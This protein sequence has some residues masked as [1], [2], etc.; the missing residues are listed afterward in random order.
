MTSSSFSLGP[1]SDPRAIYDALMLI[2][3]PELVS[4]NLEALKEKYADESEEDRAA[5]REEYEKSYADFD[6]LVGSLFGA[7]TDIGKTF[8]KTA[9]SSAEAKSIAEDKKVLDNLESHFDS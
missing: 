9:L 5:R 8:K 1:D 7:V 6:K 3:N 4:T 2:I